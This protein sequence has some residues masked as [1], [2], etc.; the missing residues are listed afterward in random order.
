MAYQVEIKTACI[1]SLPSLGYLIPSMR[2]LTFEI[3][4]FR[5]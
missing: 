4:D 1:I 3:P 2:T 5:T